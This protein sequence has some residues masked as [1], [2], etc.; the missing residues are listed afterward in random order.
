M[1]SIA[2][3]S[4]GGKT[5]KDIFLYITPHVEPGNNKFVRGFVFS[6]TDGDYPY[7]KV[8]AKIINTSGGSYGTMSSS[9]FSFNYGTSGTNTLTIKKAGKYEYASIDYNT[10]TL[11]PSTIATFSAGATLT[12]P[13]TGSWTPGVP[14][15]VIRKID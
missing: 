9:D 10:Q 6:D 15:F 5:K 4:G 7:M 14:E 13:Y 3:P 12:I 1:G 11:K 8:Y 2:I